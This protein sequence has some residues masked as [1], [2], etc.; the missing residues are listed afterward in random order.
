MEPAALPAA[1]S[2]RRV[3]TKSKGRPVGRPFSFRPFAWVE[4]AKPGKARRL[5]SF[6]GF[7]CA[8]SGRQCR[9]VGIPRSIKILTGGAMRT[10]LNRGRAAVR[11]A[12]GAKVDVEYPPDLGARKEI[13]EGAAFDIALAAAA[14]DRRTGEGRQ[15]RRQARTTD[16]AR[17]TVGLRGPAGAPK[18]DIGTVA[19]FKAALL[20]ARSIA[21]SDG[22]SGAYMAELLETR[23]RRGNEGQDQAHQRPVAE[24]VA[25]GEAEIGMQQIVAI[26]PVRA[27]TWSAR[28]RANCRMSLSMPPGFLPGRPEPAAARRALCRL[29]AT[30]AAWPARLI[31][32]QGHGAGA[33]RT[34]RRLPQ[35]CLRHR[36]FMPISA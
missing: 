25:S 7:R 12:N 16:V 15:D 24:L 30:D 26:L 8:Q 11:A 31:R 3:H 1:R 10:F 36:A 9:H 18:P 27:P 6:P 4:P 2:N 13:A 33:D 23:P 14:G 34:G 22:P 28:C 35:M 29:Y 19:A 5:I 17:S 32:G 20:D 21:Y